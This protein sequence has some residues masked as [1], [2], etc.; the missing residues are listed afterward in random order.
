MTTPADLGALAAHTAR[1]AA[2]IHDEDPAEVH[3][4][5][6]ALPRLRLE[7]VCCIALAMVDVDQPVTRLLAWV[8]GHWAEPD[9][10]RGRQ[11]A[12]HVRHCRHCPT[13]FLTARPNRHYC[14][15][16]CRQAARRRQWRE[17]KQRAG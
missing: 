3:A 5:L 6:R 11:L 17:S 12:L 15:A 8:G 4:E 14:T 16:V 13:V 1:L 7:Q 10:G 9:I 2:Q